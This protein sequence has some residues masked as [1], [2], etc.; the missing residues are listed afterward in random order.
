[1]PRSAIILGASIAGLLAAR[2]LAPHFE[3]ILLI[4]RDS[5]PD[6]P[7]Y[8][9][10]TAQAQHAHILLRRGLLGLEK[11]FP[12]FIDDIIQ[13]GGVMTNATR[14]WFT[15]FPMGALPRFDSDFE[16][17]CASRPLI[18]HTLR[19][20]LMA[21]FT[22][23]AIRDQCKIM[24][25]TLAV[26]APPR[27]GLQALHSTELEVLTADLV[28][29]A[30]GRNSHMPNWLRQQGFGSVRKTEVTPYLGY[31]TRLYSGISLP[32]ATRA[33][34]I[35]AK[36]PA[37]TRG[38]VLLPIENNQYLCTLYGFS[39]DYPPTDDDGFL[40]FA[41]SLRSD[42]IY[43]AIAGAQATTQAKAFI[44]N[45]SSYQHYAENNSWPQG[46][47]VMGDAVCSFN[48]IYGQ[49]I[50]AA[51]LATEALADTVH[52]IRLSHNRWVRTTQRK[53]VR[54]YRSPWTISTNE[55]QRW[56]GTGGPKPGMAIRVLH[57]FAD[58]L[59]TAA[60]RDLHIAYTYIQV[61][62][63][64]SSPAALLKPAMLMRI[65]R[66]KPGLTGL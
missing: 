26:D 5:L 45:T 17:L 42:I 3:R 48:P 59:G 62:H 1:M 40:K 53:I 30:T 14:D 32:F 27:I 57:R 19:N 23:V 41:K 25:L 54:A 51:L 49:G 36:D 39:K 15:L 52:N 20:K 58:R 31:A 4:E 13:A 29:D 55:D 16:F 66:R 33:C 63:M 38:G 35:M 28:I 8:R 6:A 18:E 46:L 65:M 64:M 61:L 7:N 22:N 60:T 50:T 47:L 24:T 44:K 56:P 34:I 21:Q 12:N 2:V 43:R 9:T 10:G 37:M 11:L